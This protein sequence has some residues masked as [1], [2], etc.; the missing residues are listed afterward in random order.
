MTYQSPR[1]MSTTVPITTSAATSTTAST[2]TASTT[3]EAVTCDGTNV[4]T[5]ADD[6][7]R[8]NYGRPLLLR[9]STADM[10]PHQASPVT[11]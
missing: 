10:L 1:P 4:Y 7:F 3:T 9:N 2:S 11:S 6:V 5:E 8:L